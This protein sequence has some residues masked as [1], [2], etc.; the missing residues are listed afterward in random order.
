MAIRSA[1]GKPE[2]KSAGP[3]LRITPQQRP[4]GRSEIIAE[5]VMTATLD[6]L[7]HDGADGLT[8]DRIAQDAQVNRR[9]C[10]KF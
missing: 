9:F 3:D 4:K 5:A 7:K 8:F 10:R 6:L 2:E 1:D